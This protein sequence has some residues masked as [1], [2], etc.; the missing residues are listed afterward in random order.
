MLHP[1]M[2]QQTPTTP[3]LTPYTMNFTS[4][5]NYSMGTSGAG[6]RRLLS[7]QSTDGRQRNWKST[8]LSGAWRPPPLPC[9]SWFDKPLAWANYPIYVKDHL[10]NTNP[11]FDYSEFRDLKFYVLNTNVSITFFAHVFTE[12]GRYVFSDAQE[13]TWEIIVAVQEQDVTCDD[14]GVAPS[15]SSNLVS[16][17]ISK[18]NNVNEEPDWG[19]IIGKEQKKNLEMKGSVVC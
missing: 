9:Q 10:F 2:S 14:V 13:S 17:D 19:L 5:M 7:A 3:P 15:S 8:L 1:L 11:S 18:Q 4:T 16:Q 12:P 6:L